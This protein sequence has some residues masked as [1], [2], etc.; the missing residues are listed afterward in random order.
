MRKLLLFLFIT[1]TTSINCYS[2]IVFEKG[3][4]IN[5][6]N[7]KIDCL[8]K[9]SDWKNN[10]EK[11]EVKLPQNEISQIVDIHQVKEFSI[12]GKY[13]FVR[14]LV[15][16]DRSSENINI[17]SL[18]KNPVFNVELLFL[19]VLIEGDASLYYYVNGSLVRFF[20]K[21]N[22]TVND[23]ITQ[24]VYKFY[25]INGDSSYAKNNYYKQQI[26]LDLKCE[27]ITISAI[28]NTDY[29]KSDL[30][31]LFM[32]YNECK[33]SKNVYQNLEQKKTSFKLNIRP[34]INS[35]DLEL[36][37]VNLESLDITFGNQYNFRFGLEAEFIFPFNQNKWSAI[38][39][40]TYQYYK[41]QIMRQSSDVSGG[42][43]HA[44]VDYK[45]IEV[46][47]GIRHYFF[48]K[49]G[50]KIFANVSYLLDFNKQGAIDITRYDG[51]SFASLKLNT[52]PNF[53]FGIGGK[54][55]DRYSLEMRILSGRSMV[56]SDA[57]WESS[58]KTASIIFGYSFF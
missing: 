30:M 25:L 45:S 20:Y 8:I 26:Y 42:E 7:Q 44:A 54:Y 17:M 43:A 3:Y 39:E 1:I 18:D 22:T 11:I 2:Q 6:N 19:K 27:K 47:I 5:E 38:V 13:K 34:G 36:N 55:K 28:E 57:N 21:T 53:A 14:A 23:E 33:N 50:F 12:N 49:N 16:I 4:F 41:S 10:P 24:L 15:K 31:K 37:S 35:S 52:K 56:L 32:Q 9:N 58:Y 48:L 40:P 51:S 46:P 29:K